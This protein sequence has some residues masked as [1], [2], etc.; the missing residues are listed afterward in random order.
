MAT[1]LTIKAKRNLCVADV[2]Y[3]FPGEGCM[4]RPLAQ[5]WHP[6]LRSR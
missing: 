4:R 3:P 5:P 6:R 1:G 2:A